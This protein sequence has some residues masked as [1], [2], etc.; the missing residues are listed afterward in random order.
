MKVFDHSLLDSLRIGSSL[1][2]DI[3][4][5]DEA[6]QIWMQSLQSAKAFQDQWS[7]A[8]SFASQS[9]A[10][11]FLEAERQRTESIRK[12]LD[13]IAEIR[14]SMF[15]DS[16][17]QRMLGEMTK[18]NFVSNEIGKIIQQ[19]SGFA[20]ANKAIQE[21]QG[22][23]FAIAQQSA[24]SFA[25]NIS[26]V[27]KTYEDTQKK[28]FIPAELTASIKTLGDLQGQFGKLTLPVMDW[29]SA[30]TLSK[31]LGQAGIEAQ[32]ASLGI[33]SDGTLKEEAFAGF[34]R[35]GGLD[36]M[37]LLSF[38]LAIL[39]PIYQELSSRDWQQQVDR[40]LDGQQLLLESQVK[41]LDALSK[42]VEKALVQEVK[43][44]EARFVVLDR[45][46][47]VRA[48]P[49]S[50]SPT[51]GKL[52]PR[53]VVRPIA[54]QGKWIQFEYYHWLRQEYQTGWALKKYFQRI[55]APIG[56]APDSIE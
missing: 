18:S 19:A 39:V 1:A 32:L 2:R 51:I 14:K 33:D 17:V 46:A 42:L 26:Q 5:L 54:E 13:P 25:N 37:A 35:R 41:T 38:I 6:R 47:I 15:P 16:G 53:E 21:N 24:A 36:L 43:R 50:G 40:K 12:M 22:A 49:R 28:W 29:S 48:S 45:V 10:T 7:H 52:L 27:M 56:K 11:Q 9:A 23:T 44:A 20:S 8:S 4:K 55:N 34:T 3:N 30:A 31:M